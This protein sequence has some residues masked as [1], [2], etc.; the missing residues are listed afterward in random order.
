MIIDEATQALEPEALIPMKFSPKIC[1]QVGDTK[2]LGPTV[3]SKEILS[4]KMYNFGHSMMYR[5]IEVCDQQYKI[6]NLQY[7]MHRDICSWPSRQ[8]YNNILET[9]SAL[10][11][12]QPILK[13]HVY[14]KLK[15]PLVFFDV[16]GVEE[17]SPHTK[18]T[19]NQEE[20]N[21]I[22]T[23][24]NYL[25]QNGINK[26]QIGVITF[27]KDQVVSLKRSF[28]YQLY[29]II[30]TVDSFQGDERDIILISAVRTCSSVGFLEDAKRIN[31]AITRAKHHL[32][33]FGNLGKL[34]QSK[35]NDFPDLI[36]HC[37]SAKSIE[38][39]NKKD[40]LYL[41][42]ASRQ[43][44]NPLSSYIKIKKKNLIPSFTA[45]DKA[46]IVNAHPKKSNRSHPPLL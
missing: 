24:V 1:I 8:Y 4:N 13:A 31:V 18:S 42:Q 35:D 37:R 29:Q 16:K 44:N 7:R 32:F 28:N 12:R 10:E 23:I 11:S 22:S 39:L 40:L 20:A 45:S 36:K 30:N 2:Q 41:S 9:A 3:I 17:K 19:A 46:D 33:I 43:T 34:E 14:S 5:L 26:E 15:K 38:G 27:Y 21:V 25:L 6:L